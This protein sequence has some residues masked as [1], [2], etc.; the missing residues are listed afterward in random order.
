MRV[1]DILNRINIIL[2]HVN[3]KSVY[4]TK[5]IDIKD[6]ITFLMS[7]ISN[8]EMNT[9]NIDKSIVKYEL[10]KAIHEWRVYQWQVVNDICFRRIYSQLNI[11]ENG[12]KVMYIQILKGQGG[13][14]VEELHN[15]L[16]NVYYKFVLHFDPNAWIDED[17]IFLNDIKLF[18]MLYCSEQVV[19]KIIRIS[20]YCNKKQTSFIK[21]VCYT[22]NT[23]NDS[24]DA[25]DLLIEATKAPGA[26]G[27]HVNKTN[28]A[29]RIIH[30]PTGISVFVSD[31]RSQSVN[32][33][34]AFKR[35]AAKLSSVRLLEKQKYKQTVYKQSRKI[36]LGSQYDRIINLHQN[37]YIDIKLLNKKIH[38][39]DIESMNLDEIVLLIF[40]NSL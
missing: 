29:I 3:N 34:I 13:M 39:N 18:C 31:E 19:Y 6:T 22:E 35:I 10:Q 12:D 17:K 27:Q 5:I 28:S 21:I 24:I 11:N 15:I 25:K 8:K 2:Q 33:R 9:D 36:A 32:K 7:C 4:Y 16:L 20:P 38:I 37:R 23:N 40:Y 1:N 26:G 14:D 30:I